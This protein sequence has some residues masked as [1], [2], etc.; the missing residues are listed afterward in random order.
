[1][2]VL[3]ER[4]S[5]P[6]PLLAAAQLRQRGEGGRKRAAVPRT[7]LLHAASIGG[8][9][10]GRAEPGSGGCDGRGARR[11]WR[12]DPGLWETHQKRLLPSP[13]AR[14]VVR[15]QTPVAL[16]PSMEPPSPSWSFSP[17]EPRGAH[18]HLRGAAACG[19]GAGRVRAAQG[20]TGGPRLSRSGSG[21]AW[22]LGIAAR[23]FKPAASAVRGAVRACRRR[24]R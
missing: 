3:P 16:A 15:K 5:V 22:A 24:P 6:L 23:A 9:G 20:M 8:L 12:S 17:P 21:R 14:R 19:L 18:D 13:G 4:L 1:M 10:E 7:D 2:P 11:R